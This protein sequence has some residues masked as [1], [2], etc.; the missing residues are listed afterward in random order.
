MLFASAVPPARVH[1][2]PPHVIMSAHKAAQFAATG[3]QGENKDVAASVKAY[4]AYHKDGWDDSKQMSYMDM[5]NK[6]YDLATSFYEFGWGESFHFAH[7]LKGETLRDSLKRHEHYLAAKGCFK[8]GDQVLDLGCGVGGPA[9]EICRFTN[10][11]VT[12]V[13]NNAHQIQ[14]AKAITADC[15]AR[16]SSRCKYVQSDFMKLPFE[17][18]S[19]DHAYAIE[20]TCHAPDPVA[21]YKEITRCIKPGGMVVLYE[22]CLTEAYNPESASHVAAKRDIELGNGLPGIRTTAEV[23]AAIKKAGL[24]LIETEDLVTSSEVDWYYPIDADVMRLE[25]F[26]TT[27]IGRTISRNF[28]W[29]LEKLR[30]APAGTASVSGFLEKGADGLVAGGK[31]GIF[32]PMYLVVARKPQEPGASNAL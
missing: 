19:H 14:R 3:G 11:F 2:H 31:L 23:D 1:S 17:T 21:C 10:A 13:N 28:A 16:L 18:A 25:M 26:Q 5:V 8:E 6:Y 7:R 12:G 20:A 24:E 9:R 29:T 32:T 22:W 15:G 4:E 30:I 27:R